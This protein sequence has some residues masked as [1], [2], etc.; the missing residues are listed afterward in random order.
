MT[1]TRQ[2]P[3]LLFSLGLSSIIILLRSYYC[4]LM[5]FAFVVYDVPSPNRVTTTTTTTT[6][7]TIF[8]TNMN[9]D[10]DEF[11][12]DDID[13]YYDP[14]FLKASEKKLGV[15]IDLIPDNNDFT[16]VTEECKRMINEKIQNGITELHK[17]HDKL[18]R[19]LEYQQE[20][21]EQAMTLNGIRETQKFNEKVDLLVGSFMNETS[22]SRERTHTLAYEDIQRLKAIE[23]EKERLESKKKSN[24]KS[25]YNTWT[26]TNNEW[27]KEWD[28]DW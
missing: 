5:I 7:T 25:G 11:S 17:L 27:D 16:K 9:K 24:S 12:F 1:M 22:V 14:E 28:D 20:P 6:T 23:K 19:D 21:L 3:T 15:D 18:G 10:G 26:K 13:A 4:S 8:A 2:Q